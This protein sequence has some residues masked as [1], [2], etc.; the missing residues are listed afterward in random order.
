MRLDLGVDIPVSKIL[1]IESCPETNFNWSHEDFFM[2]KM[3]TE[4][5]EHLRHVNG[6]QKVVFYHIEIGEKYINFSTCYRVLLDWNET[7]CGNMDRAQRIE[8]HFVVF[9]TQFKYDR[10]VAYEGMKELL[11]KFKIEDRADLNGYIDYCLANIRSMSRN[12]TFLNYGDYCKYGD[13][14]SEMFNNWEVILKEYIESHVEYS[15]K[16]IIK[17][18]EIFTSI[19]NGFVE[20]FRHACFSVR[21]TTKIYSEGI[22]HE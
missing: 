5:Y 4:G 3:L 2:S 9:T 21:Q 10:N 16:Y 13:K 12:L 7:Y 6:E 8:D 22:E 17:D 14:M 19:Y 20:S 11:S 18:K 1:K 15:D